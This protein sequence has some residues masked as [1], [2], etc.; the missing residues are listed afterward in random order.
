MVER[1]RTEERSVDWEQLADHIVICGWSTKGR[2]I[3]SELR[4]STYGAK[5]S[6]VIIS[7]HPQQSDVARDRNVFWMEEDFTRVDAL[8]KAGIQR[9]QTCIVLSDNSGGRSEQD[10]DARTILAALTVEKLNSE[11]YTCAE[12]LN[13]SYASHLKMGHVN[14]FVVSGEYGAYLLAQAAMSR[15][16]LGVYGELLTYRHGNEMYRAAI[17]D[18][19]HGRSFHDMLRTL[20]EEHDAI[21]IA[22]VMKTGELLVNPREHTFSADEE[23]IA[24]TRGEL[25]IR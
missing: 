24:I 18:A 14:D 22:V 21:L 15:G 19:W 17:P 20:K 23:V 9:A 13:E 3:V 6:I 10:A 1:L 5:T 25:N 2:I 7:Q 12:L 8:E 11:V 4:A 16:L